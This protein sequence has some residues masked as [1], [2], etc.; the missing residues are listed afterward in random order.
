MPRGAR[1]EG[2]ALQMPVLAR[3]LWQFVTSGAKG[4]LVGVIV[5]SSAADATKQECLRLVWLSDS[6]A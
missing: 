2:V 3:L 5:I 6:A 4:R 1:W